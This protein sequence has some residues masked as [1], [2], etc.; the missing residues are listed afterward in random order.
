MSKNFYP[1]RAKQLVTS[2]IP[3]EL[4]K[5]RPGGGGKKLS[6]IS[7]Q[8]VIDY[9]NAAFGYM[10]SFEI[11]QE[12]KEDSVD[13]FNPKYD[14]EPAPQN[15]V[16]HA[17]VRITIPMFDENGNKVYELVKMGTGS[18]EVLGGQGDQ[19]DIFKA[20]VTDG[21]KKAASYLGFGLELYRD[22][23]EQ[24]VFDAMND[25]N[26]W[27]EE[28]LTRYAGESEYIGEFMETNSLD[29][30]GMTQYINEFSGGTLSSLEEIVPDN[31]EAFVNYL[32]SLV[33]QA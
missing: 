8:T 4:I 32:K 15:P 27:T 6:Y 11:V 12:W 9:L 20:A 13:K 26:P 10:W 23:D 14:K 21:L 28:A 29:A 18:K 1:E 30:E 2:P 17:L 22:E 24:A 33:S 25:D 3:S 19:A 7:G 5:E 31:I 16:A